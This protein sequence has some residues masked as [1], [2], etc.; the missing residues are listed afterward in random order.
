M[1]LVPL[2]E[3]KIDVLFFGVRTTRRKF[4]YDY[5]STKGICI[6]FV[7]NVYD[8]ELYKLI[9]QTKIVINIHA[10]SY[11]LLEVARIHNCLR[12]YPV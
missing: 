11:S 6:R 9:R 10:E 2:Y 3:K 4:I 5:L 8:E 1:E 7:D 12:R